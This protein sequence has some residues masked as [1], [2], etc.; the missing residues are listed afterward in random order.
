MDIKTDS[1]WSTIN[2]QIS[3]VEEDR[4]QQKQIN[5]IIISSLNFKITDNEFYQGQRAMIFNLKDS[6]Y[7]VKIYFTELSKA[8]LIDH[9]LFNDYFSN[10]KKHE[11]NSEDL[12]SIGIEIKYPLT[13]FEKKALKYN[14]IKRIIYLSASEIDFSHSSS[15]NLPKNYFFKD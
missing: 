11:R 7:Y 15:N 14:W 5:N 13:S 8:K 1:I 10:R 6:F 3:L 12:K 2:S 4:I 9:D